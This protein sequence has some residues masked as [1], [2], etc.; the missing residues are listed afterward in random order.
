MKKARVII[1]LECS[2]KCPY[3]VN[4]HAHIRDQAT[5]IANIKQIINYDIILITGGE[6]SQFKG[7][8]DLIEDVRLQ[9][10]DAKIYLYTARYNSRIKRILPLL[11]GATYTLH[12]NMTY[13]EFSK[14]NDFQ[15]EIEKYPHH[16]MRLNLSPE[17]NYAISIV[18]KWWSKIKI[19]HWYLEEN[20]HVPDGEDLFILTDDQEEF[21]RDAS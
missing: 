15:M 18:P 10:P 7:L 12:D 9:N 8:R 16:E 5:V 1:T 19:K 20:V 17:I 6:P 3:C 2:R 14:F 4:Q 11:D 21:P 13:T